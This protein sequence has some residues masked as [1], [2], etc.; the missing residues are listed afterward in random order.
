MAKVILWK[1][2][3]GG[4]SY[5]VPV[6][7]KKA[8]MIE[9]WEKSEIGTGARR[10]PDMDSIDLPSKEFRN[11]WRANPDGSIRVD[12]QIKQ[13]IIAERAK[14]SVDDRLAALEAKPRR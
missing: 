6:P 5:G 14:P 12:A 3:D 1:Q 13:Q 4:I 9:Q 11:A 10:L 2:A 7:G 8:R